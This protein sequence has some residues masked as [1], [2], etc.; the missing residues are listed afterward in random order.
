MDHGCLSW[1]NV[2][3]ASC[4]RPGVCP[5]SSRISFHLS[6]LSCETR[7][8]LIVNSVRGKLGLRSCWCTVPTSSCKF[9][10]RKYGSVHLLYDP[11]LY[12]ES[13]RNRDTRCWNMGQLM[14]CTIRRQ[15]QELYGTIRYTQEGDVAGRRSGCRLTGIV[16][17]LTLEAVLRK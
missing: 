3:K 4:L 1:N 5:F 11:C 15:S 12:L 16:L 8:N 9:A 2:I 13:S 14:R 17:K 6:F 7:C 10:Q